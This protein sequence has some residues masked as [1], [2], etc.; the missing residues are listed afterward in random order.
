MI[1]CRLLLLAERLEKIEVTDGPDRTRFFS[2][3]TWVSR[4]EC[5]TSACA[6]GEATFIK[7]FKD[8]GLRMKKGNVIFKGHGGW[9]AVCIFFGIGNDTANDLFTR[10]GYGTSEVRPGQVA[11]KIRRLVQNGEPA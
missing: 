4:D 8:L 1:K 10:D 9:E 6:V 2:L 5:G 3:S 11:D 7:R